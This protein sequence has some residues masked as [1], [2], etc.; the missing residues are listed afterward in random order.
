MILALV[1]WLWVVVVAFVVAVVAVEVVVACCG[2]V[3]FVGAVAI[4]D[5]SGGDAFWPCARERQIT[6]EV[7]YVHEYVIRLLRLVEPQVY[8]PFIRDYAIGSF[9]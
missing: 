8:C 2:A 5:V 3:I 7:F 4:V 6:L 9:F 1:V